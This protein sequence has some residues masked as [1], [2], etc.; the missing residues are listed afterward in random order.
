MITLQCR[1]YVANKTQDKLNHSQ[2]SYAL[3]A[4][5]QWHCWQLDFE[6]NDQQRGHGLP[7][8]SFR[9]YAQHSFCGRLVR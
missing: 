6:N 1:L 7:V 9:W 8:V 4:F 5:D 3:R 2:P